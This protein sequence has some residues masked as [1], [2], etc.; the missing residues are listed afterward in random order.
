MYLACGPLSAET[1][2]QI[3]HKKTPAFEKVFDTCSC[4][5]CFVNGTYNGLDLLT[6]RSAKFMSIK[7]T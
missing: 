5:F 6:S 7:L 1:M 3:I 2:L 4:G